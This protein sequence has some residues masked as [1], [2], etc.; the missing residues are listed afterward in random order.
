VNFQH[1]KVGSFEFIWITVVTFIANNQI[2]EGEKKKE[3]QTIE[4]CP[5]Q[6]KPKIF[7]NLKKS[8]ETLLI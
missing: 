7:Q 8:L 4:P 6:I 2:F 3:E 5:H 1:N